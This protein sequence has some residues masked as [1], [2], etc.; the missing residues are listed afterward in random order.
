MGAQYAT[1]FVKLADYLAWANSVGCRIQT[2]FTASG[3]GMIQLTVV[4][5]PSKRYAVIHGVEKDEALPVSV[6]SAYDRRLG[7]KSPF[8]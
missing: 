6:Y 3:S 2:G 7:L 4:T 8:S 1:K 5:A